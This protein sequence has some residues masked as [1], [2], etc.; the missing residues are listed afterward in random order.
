MS[1]RNF[2]GIISSS[3]LTVSNV[4]ASGIFT[5]NSHLQAK[6]SGNWPTVIVPTSSIEYLVVSG[7]GS[8]AGYGTQV[9]GGGGGAGG[10]LTGNSSVSSSTTY[11]ITIG[12]GGAGVATN[13][14]GNYGSNSSISGTGLSIS[15][16]GGGRGTFWLADGQGNGGSGGGTTGASYAGQ[17]MVPGKGIYP[18]STY[19]SQTRQGYDGVLGTGE[20]GS[21][22]CTGGGGGGATSAGS[23]STGGTGYTSSIS[24]TST[25]YASGGNG[26]AGGVSSGVYSSTPG[27]GGGGATATGSGYSQGGGNGIVI[28]RYAD[29]F[30]AAASTTGSPTVTV[31][32]GYRIYTWTSS[33]SITF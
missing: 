11:T 19:L 16:I 30:P 25:T 4:S 1:R 15:T 33:G 7:G 31:S 23:G 12:S 26:S 22:P 9:G 6:N 20:L 24:G 18:G 13:L 3:K 21:T 5:T 28:I 14:S 17:A 2:R 27:A 10:L 29:T 32:G 8:G